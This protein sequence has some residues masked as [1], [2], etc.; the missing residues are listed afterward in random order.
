MALQTKHI[1]VA[2][3]QHVRIRR[4]MGNVAGRASFHLYSRVLVDEWAVLVDM[5]FVTDGILRRSHAYLLGLNGSMDVMTIGTLNKPFI[6][7]MMKWHGKLRF[8]L[9]VAGVA[10]FGL[11]FG[12]QEFSGL[13]VVRRVA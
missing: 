3:F 8:L 11:R 1:D 13:G 2:E 12:K 9:Q 7:T 5:A 4:T 6:D 10:E